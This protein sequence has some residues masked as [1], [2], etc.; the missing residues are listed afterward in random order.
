VPPL[1]VGGT[2][3][4]L[5]VAEGSSVEGEIWLANSS[6]VPVHVTAAQ[7]S[8][9]LATGVETGP[10]QMPADAAVPANASKR[11]LISMGMQPF[12]A[13][14]SYAAKIDLTTSAG[15]QSIPATFFVAALLRLGLV[16]ERQVFVGVKALAKVSGSVVVVNRGNVA[17][18]V[19]PIAEEA[20]F[21]V[22]TNARVLAVG[23][24]GVVAVEP[25]TG[26]TPVPGKVTFTN[27]KPVIPVGGCADVTFQ[28]TVPAGVVANRH[29]RCLPRIATDRFTID[30]L[31]A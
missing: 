12:T 23:A 13:P 16:A 5:L 20:L 4:V 31:T 10:I 27:A 17:V 14:G 30:L 21:E 26:L 19:G 9:T 11:L 25:A 1:D 29:L 3:P 22:T 8:V 7:L 24:G 15:S 28:L 18:K 2:T 6:G